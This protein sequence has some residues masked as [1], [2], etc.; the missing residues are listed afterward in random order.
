MKKRILIAS[1]PLNAGGTTTALI[2]LL[3]QMDYTKYDVDLIL[4]RKQ[5]EFIQF[6]PKEVNILPPGLKE[7]GNFTDKIHKLFI[8]IVKGI[9]LKNFIYKFFKKNL[10]PLAEFQI[11]SGYGWASVSRKLKEEY[12]VAIGIME[13]WPN[14]F[15]A[16]KTNAKKKIAWVHPEYKSTGFDPAL[17]EPVLKEFDN[18]VLVTKKCKEIFDDVFPTLTNKTLHFENIVSADYIKKLSNMPVEDF[19][20]DKSYLNI[21]TV[22]RLSLLDK[23]LDRGVT[24]LA[25]L[26]EEG[27]KVRWYVVGEGSDR[28]ELE[29][30]IKEN[31]L[32]NEFIL[33][34]QRVN[35]YPYIKKADVFVMTSRYEGKPIA[36]TEAQILG[37]PIITTEYASA[38][39][40]VNHRVD[41]IITENNDTA[42]YDGIKQVL[43]NP[44]LL[45]EFSHNLTLRSDFGR[46]SM[47]RFYELVNN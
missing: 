11:M 45:V 4:M 47:E 38:H 2:S 46:G 14:I 43:Q 35:P 3:N 7:R 16:R 36:V 17:D 44:N 42:I 32:E 9:L 33:L 24:A 13:G 21:I 39:E 8:Y 22:A 18:I 30:M 41:G 26:I 40:Q 23:G 34:G 25:R 15:V 12:D 1:Y 20:P 6:V 27:Y 10:Y 5:G 31:K 28:K 29:S 37:L 19:N